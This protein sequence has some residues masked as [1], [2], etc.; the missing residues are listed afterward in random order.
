CFSRKFSKLHA[1]V[2]IFLERAYS[3][4]PFFARN[5]AFPIIVLK[6][7]VLPFTTLRIVDF[8]IIPFR[9]KKEWIY[10]VLLSNFRNFANG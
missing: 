8:E 4:S 9:H 7:V 6:N 5:Q 1:K 3:S 2:R 10:F